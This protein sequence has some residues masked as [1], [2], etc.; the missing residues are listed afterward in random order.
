[1]RTRTMP[2]QAGIGALARE[3]GYSY[4]VYASDEQ[5]PAEM[6]AGE[7]RQL[8]SW[9]S[10]RIGSRVAVPDLAAAGY[11]FTG[12]RL[13]ATPHGPALLLLYD[14]AGCA[15]LAVLSRPMDIDKDAS[16]VST[17]YD[18]VQQVSW[19]DQGI[20]YSVVAPSATTGLQPIAAAI[21]DQAGST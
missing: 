5:R 15:R 20:G 6:G 13:V 2:P 19:A 14:R 12:G 16:M 1:M 3:A 21:R 18:D 7:E 9:A 11:R 8:V 10:R 17:R 4:R